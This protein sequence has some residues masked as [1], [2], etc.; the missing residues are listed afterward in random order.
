MRELLNEDFYILSEIADKMDL[1]LPP[2]T[3]FVKGNEVSKGQQEYG[4][5][6]V[7]VLLK[8]AHRAKEPINKLLANMLEIKV[9]E[10]EKKPIKETFTLIKE[11]FNKEGFIDFFK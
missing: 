11:L 5:E 6:V 2:S 8:R 4:T 7:T 3:K 9:E 1:E 10:V